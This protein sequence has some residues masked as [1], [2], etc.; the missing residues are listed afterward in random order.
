WT[1]KSYYTQIALD[2][3]TGP[4]ADAVVSSVLDTSLPAPDVLQLIHDK[5]GGNPLFVEEV[6]RSLLERGVLIRANGAV[7]WAGHAVVELPASV[8]DIMRA[9]I[10]RLEDPVKRTVQT[11]AVIGREFGLRL[12]TRLSEMATEVEQYLETLK[13]LEFI[14][15]KRFFPE[16]EYAFK[17]AV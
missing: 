12:I 3:L 5:T 15:E 14:Q 4:E 8:Q 2:A 9:R 13:H 6:I 7:R 17:H 16:I 1:D 10:D 11:A